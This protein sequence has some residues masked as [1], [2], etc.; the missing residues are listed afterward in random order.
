[1]K[2]IITIILLF[3]LS[4]LNLYSADKQFY[5]IGKYGR[6]GS[7]SQEAN[8][9]SGI[10]LRWDLIE[11][12]FPSDIKEIKLIRVD[13]N[14]TLLDVNSSDKMS[15]KQIGEMFQS[16]GSQRRLFEIINSI[17]KN[18]NPQCTNANIGNIGTKVLS[19]LQDNYWSFLASRVNFDIARARYRAY[20]DTSFDKSK[21]HIDYRLVGV[22]DN[23]SNITLGETRVE[24]K[25]TTVLSAKDF[26]QV[27]ES[28]CNDNRYALDDYRM[29]LSWKNGGDNSTEF[30]ANGL[31]VSGYDLYYSTKPA[32]ELDA[33]FPKSIDMMKI[34]SNIT[35][36]SNGELNPTLLRGKFNLAKANE[37]LITI[38]E[39]DTNGD[40]PLYIESMETLKDRGFK[41]NENRYYFLVP[42]DF[43]GNYGET[44]YIKVVI[45]DLLPPAKPINPRTIEDNNKTTLIW[46]SVTP[47]NYLDYYTDMKACPNRV[48]KRIRFVSKDEVCEK[49]N[50]V[51]LNFNVTKYFVYR[52]ENQRDVAGFEDKN[53]NGI[54]DIAE[55][56]NSTTCKA[57]KTNLPLRM[58][59]RLVKIIPQT[60]EKTIKFH[61]IGVTQSKEYWY[62]IVSVT[63]S[64]ITSQYTA[65]IRAFV[66]K[67]E[68]VDAP[69]FNV[70]TKK[71]V[72]EEKANN[73]DNERGYFLNN[74]TDKV[75]IV[76][77][78][79]NT[80]SFEFEI[81]NGRVNL[82]DTPIPNK[83]FSNKVGVVFISFFDENHIL[84]GKYYNK[85]YALFNFND[86][87]DPNDKYKIIGYRIS[88]VNHRLKLY[89]KDI[90]VKDGDAIPNEC[91]KINFDTTYFNNFMRDK[92]F[93]TE[94][95]LAM[96]NSRYKLTQDCNIPQRQKE[97]CAK[98]TSHDL[99]SVGVSI[100]YDNGLMSYPTYFN[101]IPNRN[102]L[103]RPNNPAI[104]KL[105]INAS[106]KQARVYIKPQI[107]KVT[108]TMLYLYNKDKNISR[109]QVF[110][111][112]DKH[113]PQKLISADINVTKVNIPDTWCV[114]GKTIG[115]DGQVS[116]WSNIVCKDLTTIP[117]IETEDLLAWPILENNAKRGKDMNISFSNSKG[118]N[119]SLFSTGQTTEY[120]YKLNDNLNI[121]DSNSKTIAEELNSDKVNR[122]EVQ[123]FNDSND[124]I[125]TMSIQKVGNDFNIT[126]SE[127]IKKYIT[128]KEIYNLRVEFTAFDINDVSLGDYAFKGTVG[129]SIDPKDNLIVS[130]KV[131]LTLKRTI[132]TGDCNLVSKINQHSNFI[133]YRS[134][135]NGNKRSNFVQVSPLIED[136][137]CDKNGVLNISNNLEIIDLNSNLKEINFI[138]K[139]PYIAGDKYQFVVL[140]FD[141]YGEI[142]SY[143]LTSP[144]IIQT[145]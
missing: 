142:S 84:L 97:V 105:D 46:D 79:Y 125:D 42:R 41:P 133:V 44:I 31:M 12:S 82:E 13:D 24:I 113:D 121:V 70:T 102:S 47:Q 67:R 88:S 23:L 131:Q 32:K 1:M 59:N 64:N 11:G 18:D 130:S 75:K 100:H 39:K 54:N 14:K 92:K 124:T 63:D 65:P 94:I 25:D 5:F 111:H 33:N 106:A 117:N 77:F 53:L 21:S 34:A 86:I 136:A 72:I 140:F 127:K 52:F 9:Q 137:S 55:E 109:I 26:K 48:N 7:I 40:K 143:S 27:I 99:Y 101:F 3:I 37:T 49:G 95:S 36:N 19:C 128:E 91:V 123:V 66:P 108:G 119:I 68:L 90:E 139:Y 15:A 28:R 78:E 20:L 120:H 51:T 98:K 50:G 104:V 96:G 114:K 107:E 126:N 132:I 76:K 135:V 4:T 2:K 80:Q 60:N 112:I 35:H 62:K 129:F 57:K 118:I 58:Y 17:S 74:L 89:M 145:H 73:S 134:T 22:K 83:K 122:I 43:T 85:S 8:M 141:K 93:C 71:F 38:G 45:P 16:V 138:D 10:Y 69:E 6:L 29:G 110:P 30:F 56:L 81:A 103:P 115:L 144:Q 116:D 61:D 87:R